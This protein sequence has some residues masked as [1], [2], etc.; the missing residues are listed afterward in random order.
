MQEWAHVRALGE[1]TASSSDHPKELS[2]LPTWRCQQK[3]RCSL[4]GCPRSPP[5]MRDSRAP[6]A[7]PP[8]GQELQRPSRGQRKRGYLVPS[9]AQP[10]HPNPDLI[11][12]ALASSPSLPLPAQRHIHTGHTP[13]HTHLPMEAHPRLRNHLCKPLGTQ[14]RMHPLLRGPGAHRQPQWQARNH[15]RSGPP[16]LPPSVHTGA[17]VPLPL[18]GLPQTDNY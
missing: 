6:G 18:T 17:H 7:R 2:T 3:P 4:S 16:L 12:P 1:P 11:T 14:P 5:D 8:T 13:T 10:P 15:G 9:R